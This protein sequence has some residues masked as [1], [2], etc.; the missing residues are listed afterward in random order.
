MEKLILKSGRFMPDMEGDNQSRLRAVESY[1]SGLTDELEYLISEI[2][3]V[4]REAATE[5]GEG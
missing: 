2:D 4:L 5:G 1:L 3:R